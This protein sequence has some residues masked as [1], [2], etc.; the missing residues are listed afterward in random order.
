[1]ATHENE[2][3]AQSE[4][5]RIWRN[6]G[7]LPLSP[8]CSAVVSC[9][10]VVQHASVA[11]AMGGRSTGGDLIYKLILHKLKIRV[12]DGGD[13]HVAIDATFSQLH[14]IAASDS[15]WFYEPKYFLSK[16]EVDRMGDRITAARSKGARPYKSGVP[17][18][19]LDECEK[20][21]EAA[22]EKKDKT[23]SAKFNDTGLMAL[24]CRHDIVI[25][26]ANV[27]TPGEQ[28]KFG[29][30]LIEHLFSHIPK[31]ATVVVYYDIG[32]MLDRS[33]HRVCSDVPC[34]RANN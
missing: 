18:S 11:Y 29:I 22:N 2:C 3:L 21:Y 7:N 25:F 30:T 32:C 14:N 17:E 12:S 13:I 34:Q 24:V 15:P 5:L 26:L 9:N 28:Q 16:E 6:M 33:L 20:L 27:D 4:G 1:M 8:V 10:S 31:Q 23:A 19:A